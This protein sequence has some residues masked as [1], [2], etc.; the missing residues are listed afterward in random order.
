MLIL[1]DSVRGVDIRN[2]DVAEWSNATGS[3]PVGQPKRQFKSD[4][5]HHQRAYGRVIECAGLRSQYLVLP[6]QV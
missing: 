2:A 6:T 3:S 5:L 1:M 4:H